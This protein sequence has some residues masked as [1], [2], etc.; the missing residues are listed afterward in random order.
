LHFSEVALQR[1]NYFVMDNNQNSSKIAAG[2]YNPVILK[3][4]SEVWN[5]Q[6]QLF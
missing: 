2:L 4:F 6:E 3:R 1:E 5:A